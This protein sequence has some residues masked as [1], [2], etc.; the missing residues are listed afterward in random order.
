M[1]SI[2]TPLVVE[3]DM[4][5]R[6][7]SI[8]SVQALLSKLRER[9]PSL[10][11]RELKESIEDLAI[12]LL[13]ETKVTR[14]PVALSNLAYESGIRSVILA[15]TE[16]DGL[17]F[18]QEGGGFQ[19]ILNSHH[20]SVRRRFSLAHEVMHALLASPGT[21][22]RDTSDH[23]F[24]AGHTELVCNMFA[25]AILMPQPF[26]AA[27]LEGRPSWKLVKDISSRFQVSIEAAVRRLVSLTPHPVI[28]VKW[29]VDP[30]LEDRFRFES[31]LYSSSCRARVSNSDINAWPIVLRTLNTGK[32]VLDVDIVPLSG[33]SGPV[34]VETR[35]TGASQLRSVFA[36]I[37]Q[38]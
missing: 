12:T 30:L 1:V 33:A 26:L 24:N 17:L 22:L 5:R 19:V 27:F 3:G 11:F 14:P 37:S 28:L 8:D 21:Q 13:N 2:G 36:L 20:N 31:A 6:I 9:G 29:S 10:P 16:V 15:D 38:Q 23:S 25:A 7:D 34:T 4:S 35:V 18:S 32:N